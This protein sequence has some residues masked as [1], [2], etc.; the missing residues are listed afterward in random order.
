[1]PFRFYYPPTITLTRTRQQ[2]C[3][4]FVVIFT[5]LVVGIGGIFLK[6]RDGLKGGPVLLSTIRAGPCRNISQPRT[7]L[8]VHLF[9]L[10]MSIPP[11]HHE[12]RLVGAALNSLGSVVTSKR[13]RGKETQEKSLFPILLNTVDSFLPPKQ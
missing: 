5:W 10:R 7:H 12:L 2:V 6:Y 11:S 3:N 8:L 1:M 13:L 9:M 4:V